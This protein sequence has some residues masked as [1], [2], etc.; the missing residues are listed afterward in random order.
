MMRQTPSELPRKR[1]RARKTPQNVSQLE[2][3]NNENWARRIKEFAQIMTSR[4]RQLLLVTAFICGNALAQGGKQ[5]F[6]NANQSPP[7]L[8]LSERAHTLQR[9]LMG[10]QELD[11]GILDGI[12][13]ILP[14]ASERKKHLEDDY[15]DDDAAPEDLGSVGPHHLVHYCKHIAACGLRP[16]LLR[17]PQSTDSSHDGVACYCRG[18]KEERKQRMCYRGTCVQQGDRST[19][20]SDKQVDKTGNCMFT[21]EDLTEIAMCLQKDYESIDPG[22]R[23]FM[24]PNKIFRPQLVESEKEV[25]ADG[26]EDKEKEGESI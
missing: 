20:R 12:D 24:D 14:N 7:E 5:I 9:H 18:P 8:S 19:Y 1:S 22:L 25:V 17:G 3:R 15:G 6:S 11:E 26:E 4:L 2:G 16:Y 10:S 21:M 23:F 13:R